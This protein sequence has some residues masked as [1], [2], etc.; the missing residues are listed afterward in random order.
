VGDTYRVLKLHRLPARRL[1]WVYE[2]GALRCVRRPDGTFL[3]AFTERDAQQVDQD[4]IE[5]MFAEFE[6]LTS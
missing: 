1:R 2:H 6:A 3:G 5:E 4:G